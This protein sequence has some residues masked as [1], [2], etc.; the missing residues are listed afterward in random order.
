MR[1]FEVVVR[2]RI[3]GVVKIRT[4]ESVARN[5]VDAMCQVV[6]M[7]G[8]DGPMTSSVKLA[9]PALIGGLK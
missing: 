9:T 7:L 8:V 4:A 6:R 1:R 5:S 3:N 2:T